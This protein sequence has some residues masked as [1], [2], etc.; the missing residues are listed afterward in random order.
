V[1]FKVKVNAL[2]K[3]E[4]SSQFRRLARPVVIRQLNPRPE[5]CGP[6]RADDPVDF[7]DA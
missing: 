6:A 3:S 2:K 7:A 4:L 1:G 5:A